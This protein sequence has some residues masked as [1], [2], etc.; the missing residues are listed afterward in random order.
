[1]AELLLNFVQRLINADGCDDLLHV[2]AGLLVGDVLDE[3]ILLQMAKPF[4]PAA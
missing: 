2:V 4:A 3:L 1:M